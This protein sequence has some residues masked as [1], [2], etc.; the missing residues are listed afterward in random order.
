VLVR[1]AHPG[2]G[3]PAYRSHKQKTADAR[4][5]KHAEAI[6]WPVLVDDLQGTV[7]QAY[8]GLPSPAFL[9]DAD[10]RIA[11]YNMWTHAPVLYRAIEALLR[12]GGRGV[13]AE[14]LDRTPHLA[15]SLVHGWRGLRRG[16]PQ[17]YLELE[18]AAPG[19]GSLIWLGYQMRWLLEPLVIRARPLPRW[20][21]AALWG[22][23]AGVAAVA[24]RGWRR[25]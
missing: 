14:G 6:R 12:Q 2:P 22:A 21:R 10:G 16:L 3:A 7:H 5:Y 25:R 13:A 19:T 8:G 15:A 4:A 11:Y 20:A 1:Q 9:I 23:A 24:V 17:S 18:L